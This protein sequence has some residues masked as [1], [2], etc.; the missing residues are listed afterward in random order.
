MKQKLTELIIFQKVEIFKIIF[1]Y[2]DKL[3]AV[4]Y[5]IELIYSQLIT[6]V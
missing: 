3:K 5:C 6:D 2:N 4:V 1:N